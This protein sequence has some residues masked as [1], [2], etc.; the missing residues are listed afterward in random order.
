MVLNL[1]DMVAT[2]RLNHEAC[3]SVLTRVQAAAAAHDASSHDTQI[4]AVHDT[5]VPV[6]AGG[7]SLPTAG[8]ESL[9]RV[10]SQAPTRHSTS[11]WHQGTVGVD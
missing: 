4:A 9:T 6:H 8:G 3:V 11:V 5:C 2:V 10:C 1:D 7:A